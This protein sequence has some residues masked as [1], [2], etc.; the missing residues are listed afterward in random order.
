MF[1]P[2]FL[3][4]SFNASKALTGVEKLAIVD[5]ARSWFLKQDSEKQV[6]AFQSLVLQCKI[7][8]EAVKELQEKNKQLEEARAKVTQ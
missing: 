1:L 3:I 2:L 6:S 4:V 5:A 7:L 8:E